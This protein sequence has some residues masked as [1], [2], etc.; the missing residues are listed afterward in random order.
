MLVIDASVALAW[1]FKDEATAATDGLVL[2]AHR[3]GAIVPAH[4]L[5]EV[6]NALL[7]A[8]RRGRIRRDDVAA[9][10][11]T[12]VDLGVDV[13][14]ETDR[15]AVAETLVLARTEKLS[16]Y[17]A[18]YLELALRRGLPLATLDR[19]LAKAA[20]KAGVRVEP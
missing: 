7:V 16:V 11:E 19:D 8:E 1:C 20:R 9:H 5:L 2:R 15:R 14:I 4:W 18:A 13:D 10:V 6:L 17:D 12:I 3:E